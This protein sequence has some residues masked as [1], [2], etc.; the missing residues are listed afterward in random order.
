M[1]DVQLQHGAGTV[2][3]NERS[4][5]KTYLAVLRFSDVL[6]GGTLSF[7]SCLYTQ[8]S[9]LIRRMRTTTTKNMETNNKLLRR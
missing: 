2:K 1:R 6:H 3:Y 5:M 7:F 9:T 8:L 4:E